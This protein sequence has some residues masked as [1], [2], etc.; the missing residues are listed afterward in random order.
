MA[1]H[2]LTVG[3]FLIVVFKLESCTGFSTFITK[4]QGIFRHKV[5]SHLKLS[6]P[7]FNEGIPDMAKLGEL[8]F[9][10]LADGTTFY[11]DKF[12]SIV[13]IQPSSDGALRLYRL[14]KNPKLIT[15]DAGGT[16]INLKGT[17][18]S[19]YREALFKHFKYRVRLPNPMEFQQAYEAAFKMSSEQSPCFGIGKGISSYEW[20]TSVAQETYY[21]IGRKFGIPK[22]WIDHVLPGIQ[23]E[24]YNQILRSTLGWELAPD[25]RLVLDG[26]QE[27]RDHNNGP[28]LAIV[29]NFD[30]RLPDILK[31]LDIYRYFDF[32]ITSKEVGVEKP[33]QQIFDIA[34]TRAGLIDASQAIHVGDN[35]DSD[36]VGA[37]KA[38]FGPIWINTAEDEDPMKRDPVKYNDALFAEGFRLRN[39]LDKFGIEYESFEDIQHRGYNN[40]KNSE[41]DFYYDAISKYE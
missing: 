16:L 22:V 34:L 2:H 33:S 6:Q 10:R 41:T 35:F 31:P 23:D 1:C 24:L 11:R 7:E 18:G 38:G 17:I 36:I 25:C 12:G 29:T 32:I 26:L 20:W 19:F 28:K 27:W 8:E 15:F 13:P 5:S 40:E 14:N 21:I 30:E 37:I 3:L 39:V 4:R 9:N